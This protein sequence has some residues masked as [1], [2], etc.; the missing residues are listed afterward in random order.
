VTSPLTQLIF[1]SSSVS[2]VELDD[3]PMLAFDSGTFNVDFD[4]HHLEFTYIYCQGLNIIFTYNASL[5]KLLV[6]SLMVHH[7]SYGGA[8]VPTTSYSTSI[9]GLSSKAESALPFKLTFK[10]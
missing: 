7:E 9:L 6:F 1:L 8:C 3:R 10:R 4:S 2:F 5:C